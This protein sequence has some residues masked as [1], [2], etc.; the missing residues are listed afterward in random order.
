[1][2]SQ[3]YVHFFLPNQLGGGQVFRWPGQS[4][5]ITGHE[6]TAPNSFTGLLCGKLARIELADFFIHGKKQ[7][8]DSTCKKD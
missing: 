2:Y 6:N 8:T 3:G 7:A 5:D 4:M 1:M